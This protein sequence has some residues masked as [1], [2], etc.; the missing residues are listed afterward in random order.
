VDIY[1]N[2]KFR[3]QSVGIKDN[4]ILNRLGDDIGAKSGFSN[5]IQESQLYIVLSDKG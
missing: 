3:L 2:A 1:F 4:Q 5:L